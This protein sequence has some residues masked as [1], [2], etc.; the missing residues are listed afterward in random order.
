[1]GHKYLIFPTTRL[2]PL[3]IIITD[4]SGECKTHTIYL[5]YK[6]VMVSTR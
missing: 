3:I 4:L 1:M 2:E 5:E 6:R